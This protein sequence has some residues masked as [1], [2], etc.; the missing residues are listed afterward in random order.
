MNK[1]QSISLIVVLALAVSGCQASG[2]AAPTETAAPEH[3]SAVTPEPTRSAEDHLEQAKSDI[4]AGNFE[5]ALEAASK[6]IELGPE[7]AQASYTRGLAHDG[8]GNAQAAIADYEQ[9]LTMHSVVDPETTSALARVEA[10]GGRDLL[11][12]DDF[13]DSSVR[14]SVVDSPENTNATGYDNGSYFMVMNEGLVWAGGNESF[15]DM[16]IDVDTTLETPAGWL[17]L[18]YRRELFLLRCCAGQRLT[19]FP[20]NTPD[21]TRAPP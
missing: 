12:I 11:V 9:F 19:K 13:E 4:E 5:A 8:L 2:A 21:T 20:N 3:A 10:L 18:Y 1:P 6:A 14:L 15:D 16:V 17:L 7:D